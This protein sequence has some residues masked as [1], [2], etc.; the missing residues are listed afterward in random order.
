MTIGLYV[1]S[2]DKL[3]LMYN[4][5]IQILDR[6]SIKYYLINPNNK[7]FWN[8]VNKCDFIIIQ[9]GQ[10]RSQLEQAMT[11]LPIFEKCLAKKCFPSCSTGWHYDDKIK[12]YYLLSHFGYNYIPCHIFY[13]MDNA[14]EFAKIANYPLVFKLRSGAGSSNV[15]LIKS[16]KEAW[17]FI[18]IMFTKGVKNSNIKLDFL[19]NIKYKGFMN[20]AHKELSYFYNFIKDGYIK[21]DFWGVEKDYV[22]FQ[23]F[24]PDNSY[25]T[26]V[27][28]IGNRAFAFRR[29]NRTNDFRASGSGKIDWDWRFIDQRFIEI[30]LKISNFFDFQ[31]MAYDFIYDKEGKPAI[32]E[33]SYTFQDYAVFKCSG[34]WDDNMRWVEG[35][36]WPEWCILSDLLGDPY[37]KS[38][39]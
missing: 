29:F 19:S 2:K 9:Y 8:E 23:D 10:Y 27:T 38:I 4:K 33:I 26:R 28:I 11:F 21:T 39:T 35:N 37:L 30:A 3:P 32:C 17:K 7:N 15:R 20:Y 18:K 14:Y 13:N 36:F 31:S 16:E 5:Y 22:I 25:D 24:C 6:N 12:Q 1:F 34:F